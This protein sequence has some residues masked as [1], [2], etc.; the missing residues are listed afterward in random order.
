MSAAMGR[1]L[2]ATGSL[3]AL[4][5][6][7]ELGLR[8][9][10]GTENV[11]HAL[12]AF[13]QSDPVLGWIGKPDVHNRFVSREFDV[14]VE[15][16]ASGFRKPEP[17]V[18]PAPERRILVL[19]DSFTWGSGVGQGEVFTDRLQRRLA[20]GVAVINRGINGV[21]TG[22]QYLLLQRELAARH[23]DLVLLQF[24]PND[25]DDNVDPKRG[26]RPWF[27]VED[28]RLVARNPNPRPLQ[29]AS[30]RFFKDHS[31]LVRLVSFRLSLLQR[32]PRPREEGRTRPRAGEDLRRQPG[33]EVTVALVRA[34]DAAA[35]EHGAAFFVLYAHPEDPL[36]YAAT[37]ELCARAGVAWIDLVPALRATGEPLTFRHDRHWTAAGHRAV[38][39]ALRDDP[40]FAGW[41][42][43]GAAPAVSS[44]RALPRSGPRRTRRAVRPT[45]SGRSRRRRA[46]R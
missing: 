29:S 44:S 35:R 10:G 24:T 39:D 18:P 16:D 43:G 32:G 40:T 21:G 14:I 36:A 46:C 8:L 7:L 1:L 42:V 30:R 25:V 28:G 15:H 17:A 41:L 19:G 37:Q 6:A 26:R 3:L 33:F 38:A 5:L 22:Q 4:L 12:Y 23:Y 20:P 9:V 11:A 27:E 34:I 2:L 45:G 13:H 31:R